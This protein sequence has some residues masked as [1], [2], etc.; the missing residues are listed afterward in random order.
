MLL[1]IVKFLIRPIVKSALKKIE[2]DPEYIEAKESEARIS[3]E[4]KSDLKE[5]E[6]KYGE[7]SIDPRVKRMIDRM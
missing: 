7:G 1:R 3:K 4:L 2:S 5:Y 6:E